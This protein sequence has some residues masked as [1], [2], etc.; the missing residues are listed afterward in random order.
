MSDHH[1][2]DA[3][4]LHEELTA[5]LDGEL[6]PAAV[7][8]VE[9][10]LARDSDYREELARLERAWGLLD[11]LPRAALD[12]NF[13]KSTIEMV[14]VAASQEADALLAEQPRRRRRQR[15][16]G[17]AGV[18]AA[19]AVGFFI[20][21]RIWPDPNQELLRDLP[22]LQNF[23]L[24]YQADNMEFLRMLDEADLFPEGDTDHAS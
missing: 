13:T 4:Q 12:E 3:D 8:R 1:A 11:R 18:L 22:V 16:A 7:S 17:I 19:L 10:R 21:T 6:E 5:Y 9:Q 23:E 20:G 24:Y 2:T 14:A 15:W